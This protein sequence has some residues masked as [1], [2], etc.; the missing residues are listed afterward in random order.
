MKRILS[1]AALTGILVTAIACGGGPAS[2]GGQKGS[3]SNP[4]A[5]FI[6]GED[7]PLPSVVS[8][9]V[10]INS[11]T[12]NNSSGNVTVLSTPTTVDFGRLVGLRSLLGFSTVAPGTYTSAT[13]NLTNPVIN[14]INLSTNPPSLGTIQGTLTVSAV[15]VN[16][17]QAM[18]VS[19]NGLAG[20]HMDFDLHDSLQVDQT[21]QVTGQVNPVIFIKA[22]SA[23]AA[24]GQITDFTGSVV[25]VSSSTNSFLLQGP[26]GFQEKIAVN[27]STQY[28]GSWTLGSLSAGAIVSV[29][30]EV[31]PDG[32][33]LASAGEVITTDK[34]FISGRLL[35]VN[36]SSGPVQTITMYIGE[37]LPAMSG[38]FA[39]GQVVTFDVSAVQT[40]DVSF[41][42]NWLTNFVFDNSSMVAGQR[43]FVGGT[44]SSSTT[45]FTPDLI[46][47]RRQGV[48]G[49]L[50]A[51]S[52]TV[53]NGNAGTFQLQNNGL[54][55]WVAQGPF[56][57][58]TNNATL[59]FNVSGLSSLSNAGTTPIAVGG[60]V[61]KNPTSGLPEVYAHRV[62]ELQ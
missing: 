40:Y 35:Q 36:P 15:T 46:S 13:F 41:I 49:L 43:I 20:L 8:F 58:N 5:V 26:W 3:S 25:S 9:F 17:P 52:V 47:L 2:S 31:Q 51:N 7:A 16:F 21:G 48:V 61:L 4:T 33:I 42:N 38:N 1:F 39:L 50:V 30:G 56:T 53:N 27:S 11:I 14:Y 22:V 54:L 32:S 62:I 24:D 28:N 34:A 23:S 19:P 60:L 37:E 29:V 44:W 10:T 57:V 55:G 12:L 59:F 45:T 18:V 6:T